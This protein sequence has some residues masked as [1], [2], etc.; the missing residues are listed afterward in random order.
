MTI[1]FLKPLPQ[2]FKVPIEDGRFP[3]NV[4]VYVNHK[5]DTV[6]KYFFTTLLT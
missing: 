3:R 5:D 2:K 6:I 1:A 4:Y